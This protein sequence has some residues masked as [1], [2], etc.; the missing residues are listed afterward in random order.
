MKPLDIALAILAA[1]LWGFAYVTYPFGLESF[2]ASQLAALRFVV[3]AL[4]AF[5]VPRPK[6]PWRKLV[7][8][9]LVLFAAQFVLLFLAY[10]HGMP[11]G[12]ASVTQQ[13]QAF[14]TVGLAA[15]LFGER[16]SA[17]QVGGMAVAL[18]G[19]V[20]IG[21]TVGGDLK[22][23]ALA[24]AMGAALSW[25]CGNLLLK[26][27]E[28][29]GMFPLMVWSSLVPPIPVLIYSH[30]F[31]P[32][33]ELGPAILHAS[34]QALAT[35]VYLGVAGILVGYGIW[36]HLLRRYTTAT[37]APFALLVP[38]TGVVS[39]AVIFG[40]RFDALRSAGMALI[41]AGLAVI[42]VRGRGR[43]AEPPPEGGG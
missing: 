12:L 40:E 16:P 17:K 14:F 7:A 41:V 34:W 37:V 33:P 18:L 43:G 23:V 38:V 13:M 20:L 8:I 3:A 42:L 9:G 28:G 2:S 6:V 1:L 29:V 19:L 21:F 10:A 5:L 31:D 25:A 35:V 30:F 39:A 24:L 27:T 22:P 15:V 11:A 36:G 32:G 4:P 26:R